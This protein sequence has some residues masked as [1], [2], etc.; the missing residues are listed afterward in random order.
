MKLANKNW[1]SFLKYYM[2]AIIIV[3]VGGIVGTLFMGVRQ[4][5]DFVGG[6]YI[7]IEVADK[8]LDNV[9]DK[10]LNT[11]KSFGLESKKTYTQYE[12]SEQ[13][14]VLVV[15]QGNVDANELKTKLETVTE[16]ENIS[17][18]KC[19]ATVRNDYFLKVAI[20][21]AVFVVLT[22]LYFGCQKSWISG[23]VSAMSFLFTLILSFCVIVLARIETTL[24]GVAVLGLF[25]V[26]SAILTGFV[27][28]SIKK[29]H[30]QAEN[31]EIKI[32]ETANTKTTK[33][34]CIMSILFGVL[35]I[36]TIAVLF[37]CIYN[38]MIVMFALQ[39]IVA[40]IVTFFVLVFVCPSIYAELIQIYEDKQKQ[41][42]SKNVAVKPEKDTKK[43]TVKR[44]VKKTVKKEEK[45]EV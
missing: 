9:K 12:G 31:K 3:L 38:P 27:C 40:I 4:S 33:N 45:L 30:L 14:L 34:L 16:V 22:I 39:T 8:N 5:V 20:L 7:E 32:Y 1:T 18:E 23:F 21:I 25:S 24:A 43:K 28:E 17:I 10:A 35:L 26:V 15:K 44:K 29:E 11:L 19:G 13:T 37:I 36:A 42:L 6:T 41:K 2:L